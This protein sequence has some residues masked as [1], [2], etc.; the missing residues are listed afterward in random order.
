MMMG[1]IS[2]I[3]SGV[4]SFGPSISNQAHM[5]IVS[6]SPLSVKVM[7]ALTK[8]SQS[9]IN[10]PHRIL[11]RASK[12]KPLDDT[13]LTKRTSLEE[14]KDGQPLARVPWRQS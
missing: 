9:N 4:L 8:T 11:A 12:R 3:H 1:C 14:C 7:H 2:A 10:F 13:A 5:S 6:P